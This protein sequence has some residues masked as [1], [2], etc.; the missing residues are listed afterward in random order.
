MPIIQ[1]HF[2]RMFMDIEVQRS[3]DKS[4]VRARIKDLENAELA[5]DCI[6]HE[7]VHHM[8]RAGFDLE[9]NLYYGYNID[10]K[11]PTVIEKAEEI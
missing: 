10:K 4:D 8:R 6:V 1:A 5:A 2:V 9:A 3:E 11:E 7:L